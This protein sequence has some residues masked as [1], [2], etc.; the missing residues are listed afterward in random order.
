MTQ[1]VDVGVVDLD[2][3]I[4][5]HETSL[6]CDAST[7]YPL[8]HQR[9]G[10]ILATLETES[11]WLAFVSLQTNCDQICHICIMLNAPRRIWGS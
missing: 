1:I 4:T 3:G 8:Q 10:E 7:I 9:R 5:W 6:I 11:P 2:Q